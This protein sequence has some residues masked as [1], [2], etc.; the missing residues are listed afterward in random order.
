MCLEKRLELDIEKHQTKEQ[1]GFRPGFSTIDHI[2]TTEQIV[3][4]YQE[5]KSPLYLAYVDYAKAFDSI[6][7]DSIWQALK[8]QNIP[9]IYINIIK[10]IYIKSTSRVKLDRL[11]PKINIRRGV[12]QGDPLSPKLF[13]AVLQ[14]IMKDLKW[15]GK[16]INIDGKYLSN[17][18]FADDIVLFSTSSKQLEEMLTDLSPKGKRIRGRPIDRWTDDLRKVAEDN[19][20]EAAGDRAQWRQLEEAYT[21]EG[22]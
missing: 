8:H 9:D 13:I 20:I 22:P 21:P 17:L 10:N 11:G 18:R 19:W 4:K 1:A 16:G 2:H 14:N 5:F 7:H 6:T 15:E 3:E 12:K